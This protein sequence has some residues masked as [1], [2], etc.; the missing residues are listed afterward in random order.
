MKA[1]GRAL[2]I[3]T[4]CFLTGCA[5][6]SNTRVRDIE[7]RKVAYASKG[8]GSP[9]IVLESG[10][11][12]SMSTWAAIFEN[13]SQL[14]RVFA[15]DRP[16]CRRS[17]QNQVPKTGRGLA[18]QLHQNLVSTDHAPPYLLVGHSAGGLYL[19]IFARMYP[20]KVVGVVLIDSTHPFQ[21]E[22]FKKDHPILYTA[23]VTTTAIGNTRY[24]AS[25]LKNIHAEFAS[26]ES[27]PNIP[28]IVLTAESSSIFVT[29]KMRKK[30]LEFQEDLANMSINATH[31]VIAGSGHFIYKD[32]PQIVVEEI[33]RLLNPSFP[34]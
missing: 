21:F 28:L 3:K 16:G 33:T 29:T 20:E 13:L 1:N 19:N 17:T 5:S 12:P 14:T 15:Y 22:Y 34:N 27:F 23:F 25:I 30:W 9:V 11:G 7:G 18:D 31:K 24:E 32:K 26:I 6:L 8:E 4:I 10:M 2:I